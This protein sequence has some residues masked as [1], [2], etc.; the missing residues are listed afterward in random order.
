MN[1]HRA[2]LVSCFGFDLER[3]EP[4]S[5]L[6]WNTSFLCAAGLFNTAS[7]PYLYLTRGTV[8][9]RWE[10]RRTSFSGIEQEQTYL[11]L[12]RETSDLSESLSACTFVHHCAD[13]T[14]EPFSSIWKLLLHP[15]PLA[16]VLL[17]GCHSCDP[18]SNWSCTSEPNKKGSANTDGGENG[19]HI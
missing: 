13:R 10:G 17:C 5:V 6:I 3:T 16:L 18:I 9:S 7:C 11:E 4:P 19:L 8:S 15:R 12:W 1:A 14:M 2:C